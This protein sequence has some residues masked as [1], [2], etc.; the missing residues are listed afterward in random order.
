MTEILL[1][2]LTNLMQPAVLF[3][4]LGALAALARSDLALPRGAATVLSMVLMLC[5]GFKGGV[6][7]RAHG[8]DA[9]FLEAATIGLAL[10]LLMPLAAFPLLRA[11][12][13]DRLTAAAASAHYGSVS[14]VTFG[15]GSAYLAAV[16]TA[17]GG[18]MSAVLAI[19]E[20]PAILVAVWIAL[21]RTGGAKAGSGP[22]PT[23]PSPDREVWREVFFNGAS[24]LLIGSFVIGLLTGPSGEERLQTFVGPVYQ[25]VLCLFLLDLGVTAAGRWRDLG[26]IPFRALAMGL[27]VPLLGA[28]AAAL[29]CRLAGLSVGDAS[30]LTIL[31]G[32]ASYIAAPAAMRLALPGADA[33]LSL[34]LAL[35][36]TFPF[37]LM[38][39]IPL[40]HA[41]NVW[42]AGGAG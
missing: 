12:G 4:G 38:F 5:I 35:G 27:V 36:V 23:V 15:A 31:A 8:L 6:E 1:S 29:L 14:V 7:A 33:G 16:G 26:R 30:A 24:V 39:G 25:G 13:L 42:L 41:V 2:G 17:P 20:T 11:T 34:T 10:S 22:G 3:F 40:F 18:Y 9:D 37:N 28:T 32:S 21:R 19:M